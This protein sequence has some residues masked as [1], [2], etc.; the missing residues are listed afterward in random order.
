MNDKV[1]LISAAIIF[2]NAGKKRKW[3][4]VKQTKEGVWE[5]P[6]TI[7]R[8]AESSVRA[9]LRMTGEKGAMSIKVLEEAGRAGGVTTVN[10]KTLP[11]RHLYYLAQI[12]SASEEPVGFPEH[13][14]LEYAKGVRKL[15]SKR[16]RAMLKQARKVLQKWEK[17][18][19]DTEISS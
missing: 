1:V 11:Q 3:F 15:G 17:E 18:N 10:E 6:K 7:V 13:L 16:E 9:I 4:I 19:Q 2:K 8:K 14:W 5:F 12:L